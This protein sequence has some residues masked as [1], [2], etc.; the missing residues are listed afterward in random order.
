[1]SVLSTKKRLKRRLSIELF[2]KLEWNLT[3]SISKICNFVQKSRVI[4]LAWID[5]YYSAVHY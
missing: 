2:T 5:F 1:M 4:S 3:R